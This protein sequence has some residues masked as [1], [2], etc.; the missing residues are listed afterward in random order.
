MPEPWTSCQGNIYS[1]DSSENATEKEAL[2]KAVF[3]WRQKLDTE[4]K[5]YILDSGSSK[6][7]NAARRHIILSK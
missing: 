7:H 2:K 6:G 4:H 1:E 5:Q 3:F